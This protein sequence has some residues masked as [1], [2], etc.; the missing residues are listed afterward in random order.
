MKLSICIVGC[1]PVA[2]T[3]IS[4]I[5]NLK[6]HFLL[7]FVDT[8]VSKAKNYCEIYGGQD[9]FHDYISAIKDPRIDALYV[10]DPENFTIENIESAVANCKHMLVSRDIFRDKEKYRKLNDISKITDVK[11]V[12]AE[13]FRFL[14]AVDKCKQIISRGYIGSLRMIQI[15]IDRFEESTKS[16][17]T[18]CDG[19]L[20]SYGLH[21]IDILL[22]IIGFPRTLYAVRL[23]QV[24]KTM[25]SEDGIV[26][27]FKFKEEITGLVNSSRASLFNQDK[28]IVNITGSEGCIT[29]NINDDQLIVETRS[30][31]RTV[32]L[33]SGGPDTARGVSL[34][35]QSFRENILNNDQS[36]M[37]CKES[38]KNYA[39]AM[40]AYASMESGKS[41]PVNP[42]TS[43]I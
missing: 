21:C 13:S 12:I 7:Y 30:T 6:E 34:M 37:S 20:W 18:E 27:I 15:Q 36:V 32:R 39:V 17:K 38:N 43:E 9:Y 28:H 5:S 33:M 25:E 41:L 8:D 23:P 16:E 1:D 22:N 4:E 10:G 14:P 11:I 3:L 29:F 42:I 19:E 35:V 31:K 2:K 24:I 26:M 40:T